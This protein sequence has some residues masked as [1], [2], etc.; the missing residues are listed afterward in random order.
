MTLSAAERNRR[1]RQR[2]KKEKKEH[3]E[4]STE[5]ESH[6][7]QTVTNAPDVEIEYVAE[8]VTIN[9]S[10]G[11]SESLHEM[12]SV[13][14]RFE[15]RAVVVTDDDMKE[16]AETTVKDDDNNEDDEDDEDSISKISKRKLR[17][18]IR[19]SLA[20]LKR[21]VKRPDLVEAHDVTAFDPEFLVEVS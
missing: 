19:P 17:E 14:R 12:E 16:A 7:G 6:G 11:T 15:E 3:E 4:D 5:A 21:R 10:D 2:K 9:A 1:K 13:L 20:D 8:P 18:I